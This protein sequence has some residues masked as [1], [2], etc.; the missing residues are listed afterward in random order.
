MLL[1]SPREKCVVSR[2]MSSP[3]LSKTGLSGS[4]RWWGSLSPS[5]PCRVMVTCRNRCIYLLWKRTRIWVD[6]RV[7]TKVT[8]LRRGGGTVAMACAE[9][10]QIPILSQGIVILKHC[11]LDLVCGKTWSSSF[12]LQ[13]I[14]FQRATM[15]RLS[16]LR[17]RQMM[18][19]SESC[20]MWCFLN[21]SLFPYGLKHFCIIFDCFT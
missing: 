17:C 12:H 20:R 1:R 19:C 3:P 11:Y 15:I 9:I 5:V 18:N 13:L 6:P 2:N 14:H 16:T 10:Q 21:S 7:F 4:V 8:D